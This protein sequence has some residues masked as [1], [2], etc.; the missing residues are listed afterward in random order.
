M[1]DDVTDGVKWLIEQGQADATHVCIVGAS[2]G[3]FAALAGAALTPELYRCAASING[4]TDLPS[5]IKHIATKSGSESER[6]RYIIESIGPPT[7]GKVEKR[8][9]ARIAENIRVPILLIHGADDTVVPID[10]AERMQ[11][12]LKKLDKPHA[13]VK[14]PGEDHWL[15]RSETRL[16]VLK[17]LETFLGANL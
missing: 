9:P 6:Y 8:S 11:K 3:G 13:F 14:L 10:Q 4:V 2:Y 16:R 17:E 7:S 15:S 5:F 1:Q 12:A